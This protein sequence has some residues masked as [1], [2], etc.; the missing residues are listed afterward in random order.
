MDARN[1]FLVSQAHVKDYY[2]EMNEARNEAIQ[3]GPKILFCIRV[4]VL[5][6]FVE[7]EKTCKYRFSY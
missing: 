5:D 3:I 7:I 4:P 1:T 2:E 6:L